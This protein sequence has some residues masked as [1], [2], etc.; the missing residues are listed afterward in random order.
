M[1]HLKLLHRDLGQLKDTAKWDGYLCFLYGLVL[2]KLDL[3]HASQ[4]LQEAINL[5]PLNWAAWLELASLIKN[6][7]MVG[8]CLSVIFKSNY[9]L[10]ENFVSI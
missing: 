3:P 6:S 2:R 4:V 10:S 9:L 8:S 1:A 5:N 7:E